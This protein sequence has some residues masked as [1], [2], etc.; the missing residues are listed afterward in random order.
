MRRR[1]QS[2][3]WRTAS[4]S[5]AKCAPSA[6]S[7]HPLRA[8][9]CLS[10]TSGCPSLTSTN[11]HRTSTS[12]RPPCATLSLATLCPV[13]LRLVLRRRPTRQLC[14]LRS[15]LLVL[16]VHLLARLLAHQPVLL[17]VRVLLLVPLLARVLLLGFR[18]PLFQLR[19]CPFLPPL[20][21][22]LP[23]RSI[24][25][26]SP[27]STRQSQP[28]PLE[29][30]RLPKLEPVMTCAARPWPRPSRTTNTTTPR[31]IPLT[32]THRGVLCDHVQTN[33]DD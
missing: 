5:C 20:V 32:L 2:R 28:R 4:A 11:C 1:Q 12:L 22:Q 23:A 30:E 13:H 7:Q 9:L 29:L 10:A 18:L 33:G 21:W 14:P 3:P 26:V 25:P 27:P 16:R 31:S 19:L 15:H 6:A 8:S 24:S 17:L